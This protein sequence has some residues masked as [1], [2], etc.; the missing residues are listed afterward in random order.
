VEKVKAKV[1]PKAKTKD[2]SEA[3]LPTMS[4]RMRAWLTSSSLSIHLASVG[5]KVKAGLKGKV[6]AKAW[7][8]V[9]FMR[10]SARIRSSS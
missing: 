3:W 4:I 6:G 9:M 1:N 8:S 7:V 10:M 2:G 5:V